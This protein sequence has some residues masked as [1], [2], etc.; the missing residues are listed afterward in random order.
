MEHCHVSIPSLRLQKYSFTLP[1]FT[2]VFYVKINLVAMSVPA[3]SWYNQ[4][5]IDNV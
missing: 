2:H 5:T 4:Q 1:N 3:E